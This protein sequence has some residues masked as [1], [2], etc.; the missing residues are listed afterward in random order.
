MYYI[1]TLDLRLKHCL[2]NEYLFSFESKQCK[3]RSTT[4]YYTL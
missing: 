3:D 1:I 2:G 4:Q